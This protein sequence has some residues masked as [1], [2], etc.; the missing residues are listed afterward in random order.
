MFWSLKNNNSHVILM[1]NTNNGSRSIA[2][3]TG[4]LMGVNAE[5]CKNVSVGSLLEEVVKVL[6]TGGKAD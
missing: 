6:K 3:M 2:K 1:S 5:D 4:L